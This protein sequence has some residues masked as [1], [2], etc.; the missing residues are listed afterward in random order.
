MIKYTR[1]EVEDAL[2][3]VSSTIIKC[4]KFQL[5]FKEGTSQH[6]LLK[7]R[8]KALYISKALITGENIIDTYT[9]EELIEALA[10]VASMMSK[11]EKGIQKFE[12]GTGNYTRFKKIIDTMYIAKSFITNE[13]SKRGEVSGSRWDYEFN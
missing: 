10:P 12:E 2:N 5:K 9:K 6:S 7:N 13:M 1:E 3:I 8:I 11:C 4:E